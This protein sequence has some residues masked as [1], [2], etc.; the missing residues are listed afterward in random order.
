MLRKK[1]EDKLHSK[2]YFLLLKTVFIILSDKKLSSCFNL[3]TN[4]LDFFSYDSLWL[5]QRIY[6]HLKV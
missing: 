3:I 5:I 1:R 2:T 4:A 6:K